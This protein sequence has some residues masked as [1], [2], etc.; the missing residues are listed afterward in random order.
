MSWILR[1][2]KFEVT[3][4]IKNHPPPPP[5]CLRLALVPT[6]TS[7]TPH[8]AGTNVLS[9]KRQLIRSVDCQ[10]EQLFTTILSTFDPDWVSYNPHSSVNGGDRVRERAKGK[11]PRWKM[12]LL[13]PDN[14]T[15][16]QR[17][18][19]IGQPICLCL[20]L[21]TGHLWQ[22]SAY[23][24]LLFSTFSQAPRRSRVVWRPPCCLEFNSR[25]FWVDCSDI[26]TKKMTLTKLVFAN[27]SSVWF[28]T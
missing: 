8:I 15:R 19:P 26:C 27:K 5:P 13:S 23:S 9:L 10:V 6:W 11:K 4:L 24:L 3:R 12:N 18:L 16:Y 28:V 17:R 20:H 25:A 22:P 21:P 1:F 14:G 7:W 2:W